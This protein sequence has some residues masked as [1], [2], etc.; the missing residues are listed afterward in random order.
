MESFYDEQTGSANP[1][2][3]CGISLKKDA[4]ERIMKAMARDGFTK[5]DLEN[6]RLE[7]RMTYQLQALAESNP[8]ITPGR[9]QSMVRQVM[10]R[11]GELREQS[12]YYGIP[13]GPREINRYDFSGN[14]QQPNLLEAFRGDNRV[15]TS[16][17]ILQLIVGGSWYTR[18]ALPLVRNDN[19][20]LQESELVIFNPTLLDRVPILG[21]ASYTTNRT[22][23]MKTMPVRY[24]K[25]LE[26]EFTFWR[27][28]TGRFYWQMQQVQIMNATASTVDLGVI[29]AMMKCKTTAVAKF[30]SVDADLGVIGGRVQSLYPTRE[31]FESALTR[32]QAAWDRVCK[33]GP[34]ALNSIVETATGI[35]RQ[36]APF[37]M[38]GSE[39]VTREKNR[40]VVALPEN[41]PRLMQDMA[42]INAPSI[43]GTK[44]EF[45]I[46]EPEEDETTV[47]RGGWRLARSRAFRTHKGDMVEPQKSTQT[48]GHFAYSKGGVDW[49]SEAFSGAFRQVAAFAPSSESVA[50]GQAAA[51]AHAGGKG[52]LTPS[53]T[54]LFGGL[55]YR[56]EMNDIATWHGSTDAMKH[57]AYAD[58]VRHNQMYNM[59][60]HYQSGKR[61]LTI[62]GLAMVLKQYKTKSF[63][64]EVNLVEG[65]QLEADYY[66]TPN[67]HGTPSD[68]RSKSRARFFAAVEIFGKRPAIDAQPYA[69]SAYEFW[70]RANSLK[71]SHW[72]A[73][74]SN[75]SGFDARVSK[76]T[77]TVGADRSTFQKTGVW[78]ADWA[79]NLMKS[80]S[81][82]DSGIIELFLDY[83]IP[84]LLP[85]FILTPFSQY[86]ACAGVFWRAGSTELNSIDGAVSG[87]GETQYAL[88]SYL[89]A[90][91]AIT[92]RYQANFH[93]WLR[94]T[95][96]QPQ[97]VYIDKAVFVEKHERGDNGE[98]FTTDDR[99]AFFRDGEPLSESAYFTVQDK[100]RQDPRG[101]GKKS[102]FSIVIPPNAL[103]DFD[104]N[105]MD[106]T[107]AYVN[108]AVGEESYMHYPTA[109]LYKLWWNFRAVNTVGHQDVEFSVQHGNSIV[110]RKYH[111]TKDPRTGTTIRRIDKGYWGDRL[112]PGYLTSRVDSIE[113]PTGNKPS[114]F[115]CDE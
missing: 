101:W 71:I 11:A 1:E 48:I 68:F 14:R 111:T 27:T 32:D 69:M 50:V 58:M 36:Q 60:A 15:M 61:P 85:N 44:R 17:Y 51:M 6:E 104:K 107:G 67:H 79:L 56:T 35:I 103:F 3:F 90:F 13:E 70:G 42:T 20:N 86:R 62:I 53:Q 83:H 113:L 94:S 30:L 25:S 112:T 4:E 114:P 92:G 80:T 22:M 93:I 82:A 29:V 43:T 97:Y 106:I 16:W 33:G 18:W 87:I 78:D 9:I 81:M 31:A 102:D 55:N 54:S 23:R 12:A 8:S 39:R 19:I 75:A 26:M 2:H 115:I 10:T 24:G 105:H 64:R 63:M 65:P 7:D 76:L 109:E 72:I 110:S 52:E 74:R 89:I 47:M 98:F 84:T 95:V 100:W 41:V 46:Y 99:A 49:A 66:P 21:T 59:H 96:H 57:R 34:G 108:T 5:E 77:P 28:P 73:A 38:S 37:G 91:D 45:D 40:I 88:P